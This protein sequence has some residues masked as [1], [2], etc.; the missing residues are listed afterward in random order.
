MSIH[1]HG[2]CLN[3]M[4]KT[5]RT[6]ALYVEIRQTCPTTNIETNANLGEMHRPKT[7]VHL[8]PMDL[9][10]MADQE[11]CSAQDC[12]KIVKLICHQLQL[13]S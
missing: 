10:Q 5:R 8:Q 6:M 12:S 7:E 4:Q 2:F 13:L 3:N 1:Q 9:H 11:C